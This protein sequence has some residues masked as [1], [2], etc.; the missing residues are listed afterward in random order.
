MGGKQVISTSLYEI[1]SIDFKV[2]WTETG[3]LIIIF[4]EGLLTLYHP[5]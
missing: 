5:F 2:C 4:T 3:N 1:P